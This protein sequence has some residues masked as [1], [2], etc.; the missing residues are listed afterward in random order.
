MKIYNELMFIICFAVAAY[1]L[2]FFVLVCY[3]VKPSITVQKVWFFVVGT[4]AV[5]FFVWSNYILIY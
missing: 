1:I 3:N 2:P 4:A 5:L